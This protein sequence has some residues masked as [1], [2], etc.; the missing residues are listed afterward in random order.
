MCFW[1]YRRNMKSSHYQEYFRN[2]KESAGFI[3][4]LMNFLSL[5]AWL[6]VLIPFLL[7]IFLPRSGSTYKAAVVLQEMSHW[8][9]K[10]VV[11]HAID[12]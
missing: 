12:E 4:I 7:Y 10:V 2:R 1:Q 8:T 3:I 6:T 5:I 11:G 9:S